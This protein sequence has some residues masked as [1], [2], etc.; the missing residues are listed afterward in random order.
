MK[1]SE[2]CFGGLREAVDREKQTRRFE[3]KAGLGV[4]GA[5]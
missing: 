3:K 1:F 5:A 2:D 4:F